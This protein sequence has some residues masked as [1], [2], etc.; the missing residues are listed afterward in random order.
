MQPNCAMTGD[1]N[2]SNKKNLSNI[3]YKIIDKHI[4]YSEQ[5]LGAEHLFLH[6]KEENILY[7]L[8]LFGS[9]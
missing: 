8:A 2:L 6:K 4:V 3:E 5:C 7:T 1:P 9:S